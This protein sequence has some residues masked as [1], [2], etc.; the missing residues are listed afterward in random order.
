MNERTALLKT[1]ADAYGGQ[2][3]EPSPGQITNLGS[4]ERSDVGFQK[5]AG[6]KRRAPWSWPLPGRTLTIGACTT[7]GNQR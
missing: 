6:S 2:I 1:A 7:R 4:V 3:V 5:P